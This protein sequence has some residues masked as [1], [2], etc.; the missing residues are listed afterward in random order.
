MKKKY[1]KIPSLYG[2]HHYFLL[3]DDYVVDVVELTQEEMN[4]AA[5]DERIAATPNLS[6]QSKQQ[7]RVM[8][9]H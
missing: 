9:P 5:Y 1:L 6:E 3:P 4:K 7:L 8:F 2:F